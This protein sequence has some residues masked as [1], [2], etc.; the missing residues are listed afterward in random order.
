MTIRKQYILWSIAGAICIV[1]AAWFAFRPPP[2]RSVR[3]S[4]TTQSLKLTIAGHIVVSDGPR[5]RGDITLNLPCEAVVFT[6]TQVSFRHPKT[7]E[8]IHSF[9]PSKPDHIGYFDFGGP[10]H[11]AVT[12]KNG[13]S[14]ELIDGDTILEHP[15]FDDKLGKRPSHYDYAFVFHDA[16]D[17]PLWKMLF[18]LPSADGKNVQPDSDSDIDEEKNADTDP[19]NDADA[20]TEGSAFVV[21]HTDNFAPLLTIA[22]P[23]IVLVSGSFFEKNDWDISFPPLFIDPRGYRIKIP[24]VGKQFKID[25]V[26]KLHVMSPSHAKNASFEIKCSQLALLQADGEVFLGP[27]KVKESGSVTNVNV[28]GQLTVVITPRGGILNAEVSGRAASLRISGDEQIAGYISGL[29]AKHPVLVSIVTAL[30][31]CF[32]GALI[33]TKGRVL[34][35]WARNQES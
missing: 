21:A 22:E 28:R 24:P 18:P 1:V 15:A 32:V 27:K 2:N 14:V 6:G 26:P 25:I 12:L 3:F 9:E 35:K 7:G 30:I 8:E 5:K 33:A 23:R 29:F 4:G 20:E 16:Q 13:A 19:D 34:G 31:S 10:H 11:I 17:E